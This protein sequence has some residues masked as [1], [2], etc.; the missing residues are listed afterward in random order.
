MKKSIVTI[1][2][3]DGVHIGHRAVIEKIVGRAKA[4]GVISI[5]VTF[6]PHPLKALGTGHL[7]PSLMSLKHR[8]NAIKDLGVDRVVVMKFDKRLAGMAPGVFINRVIRK[9][10]NAGEIFVG[11]DFCFG[12]GA[13]ADIK[14]L[15]SIG[16]EAGLKV[17]TVKA[18]KRR[19]R[20]VSSS[21]IRRLIISGKIREA[22]DLL[23]RP[24]SILGS[25]VSGAK[26]AR[27]LG[28]PTA[29]INPHHE[30]MP[31]SGVYAVKVKLD[32]KTFRGVMNIG[33]RPTFYDHGRDA[34]PSIEV[35]IFGFH[36]NIYGKDLE[37]VFVK[38]MRDEKKFNTID[39]LIEQVKRDEKAAKKI[40]R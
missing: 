23:G 10:L 24:F 28:Y 17:N 8:V 20:I 1:G 31:P 2:V 9:G 30:A 3:F 36:G 13:G 35:H 39:S 18:V 25:V 5:A 22:S 27:I 4:A 7:V 15:K 26:L 6:D 37:I 11:E 29:N 34:E 40:L 16:R 21:E 33:V 38:K 14:K 12:K 32:K 19:G